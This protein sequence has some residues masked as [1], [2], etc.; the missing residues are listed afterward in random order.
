M[1]LSLPSGVLLEES[2]GSL[3]QPNHLYL[4]MLFPGDV[5]LGVL[6]LSSSSLREWGL[7]KG[8]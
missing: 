3:E 4:K 6:S 2:Q 5:K 7:S 1:A 8:A